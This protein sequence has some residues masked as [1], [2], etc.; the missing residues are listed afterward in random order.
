MLAWNEF[1]RDISEATLH[2]R[3]PEA[4]RYAASRPNSQVNETS[5][6]HE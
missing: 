4:V 5:M 2:K 6:R 3:L 1:R